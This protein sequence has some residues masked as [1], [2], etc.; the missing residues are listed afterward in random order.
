MALFQISGRDAYED[1][2]KQGEDRNTIC[3]DGFNNGFSQPVQTMFHEVP[4][5][6]IFNH[7]G[8]EWGP[9]F[10]SQSPHERS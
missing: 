1:G 4:I 7:L 10:E 3:L 5:F 9:F 8:A 2:E 6:V